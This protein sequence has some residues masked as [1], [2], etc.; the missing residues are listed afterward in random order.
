MVCASH[1]CSFIDSK[2]RSMRSNPYENMDRLPDEVS[3]L[4]ENYT[5]SQG[6]VQD[7]YKT[8]VS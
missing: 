6:P 4:G 8:L 7:F 5:R 2:T 1:L 3:F